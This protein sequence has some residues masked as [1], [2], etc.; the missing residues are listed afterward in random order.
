MERSIKSVF[1]PHGARLQ[2]FG[3]LRRAGDLKVFS[4]GGEQTDYVFLLDTIMVL[5]NKPS[6]MQQRYRFK[7]AIKLKDYRVD[8]LRGNNGQHTIRMF[9]RVN[10]MAHPLILMT[11]SGL[12]L[13][14]WL[15]AL[16]TSMD[17][18]FPSE[19]RE[20]GHELQLTSLVGAACSVCGKM[21]LGLIGQGYSCRACRA[22]LHKHCIADLVCPEKLEHTESPMRR[23][24]SIALPVYFERFEL[25]RVSLENI[26]LISLVLCQELRGLDAVLE[27]SLQ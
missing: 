23:T 12:E 24:G 26:L 4:A 16:L 20:A 21:F 22:L 5:C 3:R 15:K 13:D 6:I 2:D 18:L 11:R 7:S 19:N 17:C 9:P 1:F 27:P 8:D 10:M 25:S 14:L